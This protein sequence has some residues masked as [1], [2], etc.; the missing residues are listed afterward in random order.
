MET[1]SCKSWRNARLSSGFSAR[2]TS[3]IKRHGEGLLRS[4][5]FMECYSR[6]G[7]IECPLKLLSNDIPGERAASDSRDASQCDVLFLSECTRKKES[8]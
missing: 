7:F 8:F 4:P 5:L 3:D 6:A 1:Q 2:K